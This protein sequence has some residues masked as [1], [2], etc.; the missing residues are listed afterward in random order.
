MMKVDA[1]MEDQLVDHLTKRFPEYEGILKIDLVEF[2]T[3][4]TL[5]FGSIGFDMYISDMNKFKL[6]THEITK[7]VKSQCSFSEAE[8]LNISTNV[9]SIAPWSL[10]R[11]ILV[12]GFVLLTPHTLL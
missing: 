6:N 5:T 8:L 7:F 3:I 2:T 11:G 12:S 10:D 1:S 9:R 4:S